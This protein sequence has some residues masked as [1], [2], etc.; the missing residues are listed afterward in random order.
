[1][2]RAAAYDGR[3]S[4]DLPT[5]PHSAAYFNEQRDFWWNA[6]YLGLVAARLGLKR[7]RSALDVG[8]GMGH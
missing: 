8:A 5:E 4:G 3:M 1:V 7:A 2:A 6:D